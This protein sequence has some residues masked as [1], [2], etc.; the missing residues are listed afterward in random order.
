MTL[1]EHA[2][3]GAVLRPGAPNRLR[4]GLPWYRSLPLSAVLGLEL[5]LDG[6]PVTGLRLRLPS[7]PVDV[8]ELAD[9]GTASWFVQD[10]AVLEWAGPAPSSALPEVVLRIRLQLPNLLGPGA[11][12]VQVVQEVRARLPVEAAA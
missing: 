5:R 10:R 6:E 7:G 3:R 9:P 2:L 8:A 12:A 11:S 4:V 1:T